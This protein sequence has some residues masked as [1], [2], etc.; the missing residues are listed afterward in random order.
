MRQNET[1]EKVSFCLIFY[2]NFI[3]FLIFNCIINVQIKKGGAKLEKTD[4]ELYKA[5]LDGSNEAFKEIILR[6]KNNLIYFILKYVKNVDVAEDISQDVFVYILSNKE[7]Y[8]SKYELKTYLYIIAKSRALNYLK[9]ER[10]IVNMYDYEELY[11]E[12]SN[13]EELVFKK[14]I[15]DKVKF[16]IKTM[17]QNYQIIIYLVDFEK[18]SYKDVA[19]IMNKSTSQVKA[20]IHNARIKL[21]KIIE[22]EGNIL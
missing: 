10:K 3:T 14:Q 8:N 5:F 22:K 11:V 16:A 17:K 1:L 12:D 4:R 6:H 20:L 2:S 21:K 9:K 15:Q 18:L 19:K 13:L 7:K